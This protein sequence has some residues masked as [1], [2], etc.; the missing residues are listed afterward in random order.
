MYL[1]LID[2]FLNMCVAPRTPLLSVYISRHAVYVGSVNA[3]TRASCVSWCVTLALSRDFLPDQ[4]LIKVH[5][6]I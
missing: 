6:P 1:D 3:S 5:E 2:L 4:V